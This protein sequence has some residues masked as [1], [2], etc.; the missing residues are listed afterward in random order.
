MGCYGIGV[1]RL[2][3]V[4]A[5]KFHDEKGLA[6]PAAVAPFD[7]H[8]LSLRADEEAARVATLLAEDGFAVLFDDRTKQSAGEKFAESELIG[9]PVQVIVSERGIQSGEIEIR[10]RWDLKKATRVSATDASKI[11]EQIRTLLEPHV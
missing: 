3:G 6:W 7:V 10:P 4:M 2:V 1:S 5:E 11:R 8:L 9:I